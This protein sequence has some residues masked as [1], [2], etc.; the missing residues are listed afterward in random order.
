MPSGAGSLAVVPE[1]VVEQAG[2]GIGGLRR[3]ARGRLPRRPLPGAVDALPGERDR[4]GDG[5]AGGR[6][7]AR[8]LTGRA[9]RLGGRRRLAAQGGGRALEVGVVGGD[10]AR[11]RARPS[12]WMAGIAA[13]EK[14]PSVWKNRLMLGAC[15]PR[16]SNTG[17]AWSAKLPSFRL[18]VCSSRRKGGKSWKLR[19]SASPCE[20][21]ASATVLTCVNWSATCW[22]E[23]ATGPTEAAESPARSASA[24]FCWGIVLCTLSVCRHS[25]S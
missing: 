18:V 8:A 5:L 15:A 24:L 12:V 19:S 20:A 14:G 13:L 6:R 3:G 21:V 17:A 2:L 16:S 23:A 7:C 9:G 22:R 10:R 1:E 4:R 25:A 11:C